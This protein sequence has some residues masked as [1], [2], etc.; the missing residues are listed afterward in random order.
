MPTEE[1]RASVKKIKK[2]YG[3]G[4]WYAQASLLLEEKLLVAVMEDVLSGKQ[5]AFGELLKGHKSF[6]AD[7]AKLNKKMKQ[8]KAVV[9]TQTS[10]VRWARATNEFSD[11]LDAFIRTQN[12]ESFSKLKKFEKARLENK[13]SF[14]TLILAYN[15]GVASSNQ[16]QYTKKFH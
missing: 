13:G 11:S 9:D 2:K 1:M 8:K 4:F 6:S 16:I 7:L 15:Q 5:E 14:K 12:Q 10:Y 3:D